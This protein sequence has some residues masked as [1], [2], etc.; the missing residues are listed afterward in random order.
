MWQ[1]CSSHIGHEC[2][3]GPNDHWLV[4]LELEYAGWV[5]KIL[6]LNYAV[7]KLLFSYIIGWKQIMLQ[8]V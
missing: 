2:V 7:P 4:F 8:I 3:L 6:E 1:W 5:E